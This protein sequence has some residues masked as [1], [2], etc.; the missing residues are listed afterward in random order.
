MGDSVFTCP[1]GYFHI[2]QAL[3]LWSLCLSLF[4]PSPTNQSSLYCVFARILSPLNRAARLARP[5]WNCFWVGFWLINKVQ[6]D[7]IMGQGPSTQL[8]TCLNSVCNGRT[9]CVGY[10]DN[11]PLYQISWVDRYNL[12]IP[13][14]PIAVTRPDNTQDVAAFVKCAI[15]SNVKVQAKSGGHSYA[16][17]P[18]ELHASL[19]LLVCLC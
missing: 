12:D 5:P 14:N 15:A 6:T 8:A 9:S 16:Y 11:N 13:V 18:H 3:A 10:P 7:V 19:L 4:R 1:D 2:L 17:V